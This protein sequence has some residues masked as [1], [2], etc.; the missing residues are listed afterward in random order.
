MHWILPLFVDQ[1]SKNT[2]RLLLRPPFRN[3]YH[4]TSF[5]AAEENFSLY[6]REKRKQKEKA[7]GTGNGKGWK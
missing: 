5:L 3:F 7:G 6:S 4:F 1:A 2:E